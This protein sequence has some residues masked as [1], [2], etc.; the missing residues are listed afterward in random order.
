MQNLTSLKTVLAGTGIDGKV[1]RRKLRAAYGDSH[2]KNT[3]WLFDHR[4]L[5]KVCK[6]LGLN[7][8]KAKKV[9]SKKV[10]VDPPATDLVT[11]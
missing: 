4:N 7:V 3:P 11:T 6:I 8:P 5:V 9:K 10:E 1:A 2:E